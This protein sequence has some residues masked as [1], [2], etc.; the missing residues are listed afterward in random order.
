MENND[1]QYVAVNYALWVGSGDERQEMMEETSE[2]EPFVFISGVG[3]TLDRFEREIMALRAGQTFDFTIPA[4]EAYGEYDDE[5]VRELE[6]SLFEVDGKL[7]TGVIF[8]GNTVAL[9][10][11]DGQRYNAAIVNVGDSTVTVDFNHP[12][13]GE[14]LHFVGKVLVKRD[15]TGQEIE[16]ALRPACGG[17]GGGHCGSGN[18][19]GDSGDGCGHC[20]SGCGGCD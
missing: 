2:N 13:A 6:R 8:E 4:A 5:G 11:E 10:G 17:C 3:M 19:G 18:C 15:A 12:L 7:D 9:L 16:K 1:K 14:D 20:G